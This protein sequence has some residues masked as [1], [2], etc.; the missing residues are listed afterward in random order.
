MPAR[1]FRNVGARLKAHWQLKLLLTITLNLAFW[2]GYSFLGRHVF[3]PIRTPP[4]TWFDHAI[5]F[6]PVP[7][8][9]VYLSQF[10]FVSTLPW[11]LGT[12]EGL[13]RYVRG[14]AFICGVSFSIFLFCPVAAPRPADA[15]A[16]GAMRWI[17]CYDGIFNAFPSLHAAFLVYLA[18]LGWR[19]FRGSLPWPVAAGAVLWAGL[20]LYATIATRQHYAVDLVAGGAIGYLA[21]WLAWRTSPDTSA[22]QAI[23][24]N[25]GVASQDG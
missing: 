9:W 21:D 4:Q 3:F 11:L 14:L 7:W 12:R 25:S 24:R 22:A 6:Q 20:I 15:A 18:A 17:I 5:P 19:I 2:G 8:A 16:I 1:L 23:A 10:L 13:R